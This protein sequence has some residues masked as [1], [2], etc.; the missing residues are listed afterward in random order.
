MSDVLKRASDYMRRGAKLTS[1]TCPVCGYMLLKM[2]ERTVCPQ[3]DKEVIVTETK[4][5]YVEASSR[6]VL[7]RL[8]EVLLENISN[9]VGEGPVPL[10]NLEALE[11]LDRYVSILGKLEALLSQEK[12]P[13]GPQN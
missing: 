9:L 11:L 10:D 6:I 3:C 12:H 5:E 4:E 1:E 13:R 7:T 8:R 2:E